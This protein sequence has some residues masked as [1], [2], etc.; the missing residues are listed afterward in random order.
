MEHNVS[1]KFSRDGHEAK[2]SGS[3]EHARP[4]GIN[5]LTISNNNIVITL[6]IIITENDKQQ[7]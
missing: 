3:G 2:E 6:I 7:Q 5:F 1:V 4:I